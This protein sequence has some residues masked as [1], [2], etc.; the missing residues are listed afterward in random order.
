MV[1][2]LSRIKSRLGVYAVT[3]NHEFYAGVDKAVRFM[4]Q[5]GVCVLRNRWV[6]IDSI[7]NLVGLD[8]M[9]EEQQL[10]RK[11]P[12]LETIMTGMDKSLP[13]IL[14]YHTPIRLKNAEAA[15]IDLQLSGHTHKGQLFPF[16]LITKL[17]YTV[18]SGYARIGKMQI[19][20]SNGV[21]TW[22]PPLRVGAPPEIVQIIL[23]TQ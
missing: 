16:N 10:G 23:H 1:E 17:V 18:D 3:G 7:L 14:M 13:T 22:G 11:N 15:G 8:Y 21:G 6:T 4:E 2:P 9:T 19:Y 20:V 12:P 5:A